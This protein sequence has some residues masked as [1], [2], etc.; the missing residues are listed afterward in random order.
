MGSESNCNSGDY[1]TSQDISTNNISSSTTNHYYQNTEN[2]STKNNINHWINTEQPNQGMNQ[3]R[4]NHDMNSHE[5]GIRSNS[6]NK[7]KTY[8]P[9]S[10]PPPNQHSSSQWNFTGSPYQRFYNDNH[11]GIILASNTSSQQNEP[12]MPSSSSSISQAIIE[13]HSHLA[14]QMQTQHFK[15]VYYQGLINT[16]ILNSLKTTTSSLE[17]CDKLRFLSILSTK[18]IKYLTVKKFPR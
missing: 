17:L 9:N 5:Q 1:Y 14:H 8:T 10:N 6:E 18:I 11:Y 3:S 7:N 16:F 2:D 12:L 15:R 4:P 13:N